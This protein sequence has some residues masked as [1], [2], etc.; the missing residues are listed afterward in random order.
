MAPPEKYL[1]PTSRELE[2]LS[3]AKVQALIAMAEGE[4]KRSTQYAVFGMA[5]GTISFLSC[6]G[7]FVF[8]VV[9]GHDRAAEVILGTAVLTIVGRMLRPR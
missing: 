4:S 5:C 8:L 2:P 9:Q 3:D 1:L 7:S 6:V